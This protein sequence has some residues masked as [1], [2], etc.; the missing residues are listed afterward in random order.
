MKI[1]HLC[2]VASSHRYLLLPQLVA[3]REAGHDVI[4]VSA[5]G[6]DVAYLERAGI[7]HR[8]LEGST[9][10]FD[11]RAD[12][13]AM[14]SF[15]RIVR[16]E[17]PDLVHTHNPKPG[18]YGRVL[19]RALGVD[20]VVNTVHG[21]YATPEDTLV[22]RTVVYGLEALASRCSDLELMQNIEDLELVTS[23]RIS[24]PD[25]VRLLGN[26]IDIDRFDTKLSGAGSANGDRDAI[27]REL[28]VAPEATVVLSVGRLVAEKGIPELLA[29][30]ELLDEPNE[31]LIV[32]P[33]D[34][35]KADGLEPAL[36]DR[37]T[38]RGVQFLGHRLDIER[39]LAAADIFVLASHREGFPRSVMEAAAAGLAVVATDIR[40][41]RQAVDHGET[42]LLVPAG[43]VSALADAIS[44]LIADP[45]WRKQL[46]KAGR[47]KAEESFDE[48]H[49]IDRLFDGYRE[50]AGPQADGRRLSGTDPVA[51]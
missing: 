15:A 17:R 19:S 49:V 11:L 42:G 14:R 4:A 5:D 25:R 26:G 28:G 46:G 6:E 34:P 38:E 39:L 48:R 22:R 45:A 16:Q 32:G 3:L 21:L 29:A 36:I 35:E 33:H 37:A 44:A 8:P 24:P 20:H 23:T 1:L 7:R 43:D 41:C 50:L 27:R 10:G 51:A 13:R 31:L 47:R 30:S 18:I 2:T 12:L 40:G 9:R